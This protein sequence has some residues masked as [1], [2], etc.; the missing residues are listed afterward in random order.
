MSRFVV[1]NIGGISGILVSLFLF[2]NKYFVG[3]QQWFKNLLK[4]YKENTFCAVDTCDT[5][6]HFSV[7]KFLDFLFVSSAR[8]AAPRVPRHR[9]S[10]HGSKTFNLQYDS[11]HISKLRILSYP[12]AA[13]PLR[14]AH[15]VHGVLHSSETIHHNHRRQ[16][17]SSDALDQLSYP[18]K[19]IPPGFLAI[20]RYH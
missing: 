14:C 5:T 2:F 18:V 19:K 1:D 16:F 4:A 7:L 3:K 20:T 8:D 10:R 6:R 13:E 15:A 17:V 9:R 12:P 11:C